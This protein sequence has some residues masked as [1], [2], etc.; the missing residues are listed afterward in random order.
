M[1]TS[2]GT[3]SKIILKNFSLSIN[4]FQTTG[5]WMTIQIRLKEHLIEDSVWSDWFKY[6]TS[7]EMVNRFTLERLPSENSFSNA[8]PQLLHVSGRS[9][10]SLGYNTFKEAFELL[11]PPKKDLADYG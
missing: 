4:P 5:D 9:C 7:R 11:S 10:G 1:E 8:N 2:A 6:V 3:L